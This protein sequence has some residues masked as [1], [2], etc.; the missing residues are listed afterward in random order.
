MS[1]K[2]T[3]VTLPGASSSSDRTAEQGNPW[4]SD[5]PCPNEAQHTP[6][7][8]DYLGWHAWAR[9]MGKTHR[10]VRCPSCGLWAIWVEKFKPSRRVL[11]KRLKKARAKIEKL[12]LELRSLEDVMQERDDREEQVSAMARQAGCDQEFSNLHDHRMCVGERV[13]FIEAN[14]FEKAAKLVE[15][16]I[17]W[18][19]RRG[20]KKT[21]YG[22]PMLANKIRALKLDEQP[23]D[24]KHPPEREDG[25]NG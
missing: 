13:A 19:K 23:D 7:P 12:R 6:A 5:K 2:P 11:A 8:S 22:A 16:E 4:P 14:A 20:I 25:S 18:W 21:S 15:Q 24:P 10:Q 17:D 9:K 3:S 1:E